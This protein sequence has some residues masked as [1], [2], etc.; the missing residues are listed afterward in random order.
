MSKFL[1]SKLDCQ[2]PAEHECLAAIETFKDWMQEIV[3]FD[4]KTTADLKHITEIMEEN[5]SK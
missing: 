5:N 4:C 3:C 1:A 2:K